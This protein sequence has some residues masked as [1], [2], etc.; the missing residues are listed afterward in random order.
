MR[1]LAWPVLHHSKAASLADSSA[2]SCP[3][4]HVLAA[5]TY[6]AAACCCQCWCQSHD[7]SV[8][9][10]LAAVHTHLQVQG[11]HQPR[12][13]GQP[14]RHVHSPAHCVC[15]EAELQVACQYLRDTAAQLQ[16]LGSDTQLLLLCGPW[17]TNSCSNG[18]VEP[19]TCTQTAADSSLLSDAQVLTDWSPATV[20]IIMHCCKHSCCVASSRHCPAMVSLQQAERDFSGTIKA[21]VCAV[22]DMPHQP[23]LLQQ[24]WSHRVYTTAN[25]RR[26]VKRQQ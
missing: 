21:R 20:V 23:D 2:C 24:Y 1:L 7:S 16:Q 10:V 18:Y 26:W 11:G 3:P 25:A 8:C 9:I 19:L 6:L 17:L 15:C 22:A 14:G 13:P 5:S 12:I 4:S